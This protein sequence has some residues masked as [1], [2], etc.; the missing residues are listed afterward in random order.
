MVIG[1]SHGSTTGS[2]PIS[3]IPS[4][5]SCRAASASLLIF[6]KVT[7]WVASRPVAPVIDCSMASGTAEAFPG[8]QAGVA[9]F[10]AGATGQLS[11]GRGLDRIQVALVGGRSLL[12]VNQLAV[13]E[14]LVV[15]T[16]RPEPGYRVGGG[17]ERACDVFHNTNFHTIATLF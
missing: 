12:Q 9:Q 14:G 2:P 1:V 15:G 7:S 17:Q 3:S 6:P 11:G 13:G 8:G 10:A 16:A 5:R 4:S